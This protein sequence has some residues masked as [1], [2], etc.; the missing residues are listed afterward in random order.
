MSSAEKGRFITIEGQDGAGKTSNLAFARA[1]LEEANV[2]VV[3]TREPGG[4][5]LGEALR[6]LLL[7]GHDLQIDPM[8]ELLMIFAARAQHLRQQ[9]IPA[10]EAGNWV[11]CDRFTDAT[12]AYQSGGRGLPWDHVQRLETMVQR[13]L[14]PDLTLL[15]DVDLETG[16]ARSGSRDAKTSDRFESEHDAFKLRVRGT[17]K[18]L[19]RMHPQRIKIIDAS[20]GLDTVQRQIHEVLTLFLEQVR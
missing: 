9:I 7:N 20:S 14:R 16:L 8:A 17:Y 2:N 13:G 11:L 19:A 15:L 6:E 1:L 3:V 5:R 10:L 12:F 18:N 4:T